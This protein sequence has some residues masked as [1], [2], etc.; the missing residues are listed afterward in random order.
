MG[1]FSKKKKVELPTTPP[2]NV[3][4]F[5]KQTVTEKEILPEQIKQDV[6]VDQPLPTPDAPI[7]A[8][9]T[10]PEQTQLQIIK[11]FFIR[12]QHYQ[13][14]LGE[15][16][17]LKKKSVVMDDLSHKLEKS[18]YSVSSFASFSHPCFS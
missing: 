1:W 3:L 7:E 6:G 13:A 14:L 8:P 16:D 12:A 5:P 15:T 4:T 17:E 2:T 18:E 9:V 11:P 10:A